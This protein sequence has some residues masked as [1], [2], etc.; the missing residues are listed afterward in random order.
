MD[1]VP[2]DPKSKGNKGELA[3]RHGDC[4]RNHI[5]GRGSEDVS[6]E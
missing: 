5:R 4:D 6:N 1:P 3:C 2:I